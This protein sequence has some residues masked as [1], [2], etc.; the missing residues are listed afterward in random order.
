M[1][2]GTKIIN[3]RK[4]PIEEFIT[5]KFA[6]SQVDDAFRTFDEKKGKCIKVGINP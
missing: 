5:H 6:L 3:S 1:D 2:K 4:F